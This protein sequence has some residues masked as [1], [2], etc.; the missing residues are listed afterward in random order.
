MD[1]VRPIYGKKS[2]GLPMNFVRLALAAVFAAISAQA[3]ADVAG[4]SITL[5]ARYQS[6]YCEGI[7]CRT[8]PVTVADADIYVSANRRDIFD[9]YRTGARGIRSQIGV[10]NER[11]HIWQIRGNK[12]ITVA[13]DGNSVVTFTYSLSGK[14]CSFSYKTTFISGPRRHIPRVLTQKCTVSEGNIYADR[15]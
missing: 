6:T 5:R 12:L 7:R 3:F 10:R 4:K 8:F 15:K 1:F 2:G 9:Y 14:T 11:G 13:R